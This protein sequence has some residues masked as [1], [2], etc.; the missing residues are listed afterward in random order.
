MS[1]LETYSTWEVDTLDYISRRKKLTMMEACLGNSGLLR[2]FPGWVFTDEGCL[3]EK[4]K[5]ARLRRSEVPGGLEC[6]KSKMSL[7]L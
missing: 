1:G 6:V 3:G 7:A 5:P 2:R 4:K